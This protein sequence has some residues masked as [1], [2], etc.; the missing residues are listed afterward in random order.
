MDMAQK[1]EIEIRNLDAFCKR[2]NISHIH[3]LKL[4]VEGHETRVIEG[5]KEMIR[6]G[7]IDFIQFEFGGCNIDSK[8]YFKDFYNLLN[9]RFR[10]YRIVRDGV[11]PIEKYSES[12]ESFLTTNYLA[13]RKNL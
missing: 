2:E 5:A 8:T 9:D 4:D 7:A 1:E 11:Y 3:F 12:C 6:A 10:I 13:E